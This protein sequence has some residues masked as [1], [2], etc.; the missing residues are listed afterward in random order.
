MR[1][2]LSDHDRRIANIV[3]VGTVSAFQAGAVDGS[4]IPKVQIDLGDLTTDWLPLA[5]MRAGPNSSYDTPEIG[6]Q[7]LL[8]APSGELANAYVMGSIP[9]TSKPSKFTDQNNTGYAWS[10]GASETYDREGHHY[11]LNIPDAGDLT[12]HVGASTLV[13]NN[14]AIT[15]KIGGTTLTLIDGKATLQ[16]TEFDV[17]SPTSNFSGNVNV[18]GALGVSG[19]MSVTGGTGGATA[20]ITGP[21]TITGQTTLSG[22][23]SNGKNIGSTHTHSGV[24]TG[25]GNSGAPI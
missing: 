2:V 3:R 20:T 22:V 21:V 7:V 5:M 25:S 19:G 23:T 4:A 6:E 12:L 24:Q 17:V 10:D 18:T 13:L 9:Q 15:A 16:T 8:F 14:G 1:D 11:V